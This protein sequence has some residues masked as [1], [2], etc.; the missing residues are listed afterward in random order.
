MVLMS[1]PKRRR[2]TAGRD[3]LGGGVGGLVDI[4]TRE[5]ELDRLDVVK[6]RARLGVVGGAEASDRHPERQGELAEPRERVGEKALAAGIGEPDRVQHPESG[7]GDA[8]RGVALARQ[9][10]DRLRHEP[11]ELLRHVGRDERV[12]AAGCVKQQRGPALRRT[13]A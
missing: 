4:R 8:W 5:I 7:L 13:D 12:E 6:R 3:D 9:R 11:V 10:R 1:E 2:G